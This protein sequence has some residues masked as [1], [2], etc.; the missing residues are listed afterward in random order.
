MYDKPVIYYPLYTLAK[1][2]I[3]DILI[4][5]TTETIPILESKLG[6]GNDLGLKLSYK[7]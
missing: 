2:G 4:I 5:S 3:K 6:D 7:I 1:T